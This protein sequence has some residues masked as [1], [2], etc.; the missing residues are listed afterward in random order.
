MPDQA[1]C[2]GVTYEDSVYDPIPGS[3]ADAQIFAD[4][5][6][7]MGI[8]NV[9][10][11]TGE[12]TRQE[13][14]DALTEMVA[15][16]EPGDNLVFAFAGHGGQG[17]DPNHAEG[18]GKFECIFGSDAQITDA[19]LR[20]ILAGL[21]EGANMT[22]AIQ[23]CYAGGMVEFNDFASGDIAANVVAISASQPYEV[24]YHT[25]SLA[26]S[27]FPAALE[28]VLQENPGISW[29]DAVHLINEIDGVQTPS[30]SYNRPE[31]SFTR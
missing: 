30:L 8:D 23:A 31:G 4:I 11:V 29:V 16:A 14:L 2:I 21:P 12:V 7:R 27:F 18:D 6:G 19:E 17:A 25:A 9:R 1:V 20:A 15:Q 13:I 10:P 3:T 24:S 26:P 22:L 5:A 28:T